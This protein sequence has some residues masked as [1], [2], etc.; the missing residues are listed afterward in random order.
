M[1]LRRTR[2]GDGVE[3]TARQ[4]AEEIGTSI[5]SVR[6]SVRRF[7]AGQIPSNEVGGSG[8]ED[9]EQHPCDGAFGTGPARS[10]GAGRRPSMSGPHLVL[11]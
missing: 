5:H 6:S 10:A 11:T 3:P 9:S 2:E 1:V 7:R 8:I 4:I